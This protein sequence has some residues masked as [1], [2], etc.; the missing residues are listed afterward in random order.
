MEGAAGCCQ[1]IEIG[2]V[3]I[4]D[5]ERG[6][7]GP[8]VI[9]ADQQYV[10]TFGHTVLRTMDRDRSQ[11]DKSGQQRLHSFDFWGES[12]DLAVDVTVSVAVGI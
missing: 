3:N 9:D 10:R 7:F 2:R 6:Q 1:R 5:A 8:Q 12:V 4:F 11:Q